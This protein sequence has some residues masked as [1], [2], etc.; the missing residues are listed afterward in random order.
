MKALIVYLLLS[1]FQCYSLRDWL[2]GTEESGGEWILVSV[3]DSS[4]IIQ[5]DLVGDNPC[6]TPDDCGT[7]VFVYRVDCQDCPGLYSE[8]VVQWN[9]P[10]INDNCETVISLTGQCN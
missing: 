5:A 2:D 1:L 9:I 4:T 6:L 8:T 3:P 10:C 7:Y